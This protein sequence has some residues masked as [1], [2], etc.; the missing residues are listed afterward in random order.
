M[1]LGPL[2]TT[3]NISTLTSI[4]LELLQDTILESPQYYLSIIRVVVVM[5]LDSLADLIGP[6]K[7]RESH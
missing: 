6:Q 5:E 3:A 7:W 4:V 2:R 1:T